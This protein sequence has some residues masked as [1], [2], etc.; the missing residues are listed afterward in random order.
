MQT[1]FI[2]DVPVQNSTS[3]AS[4]IDLLDSLTCDPKHKLDNV[5]N[6]TQLVVSDTKPNHQSLDSSVSHVKENKSFE[7]DSSQAGKNEAGIFLL[8]DLCPPPPPVQ[9][10]AKIAD[11]LI[12]VT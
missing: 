9:I 2:P 7:Q 5:I 4:V 11:W 3:Q 8:N 6:S 12:Y 1:D 10:C